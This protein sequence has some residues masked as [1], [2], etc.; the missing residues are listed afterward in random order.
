MVKTNEITAPAVLITD[1]AETHEKFIYPVTRVLAPTS[2]G[3][4]G[5]SGVVVYSQDKETYVLTNNHVIAGLIDIEEKWNSVAQRPLK[6]E[7]RS[8]AIVE[9]FSYE[10]MSR[11]TDAVSKKAD[12]VAWDEQKDLAL[13][14]LK[15]TVDVEYIA[16]IMHPREEVEKLFIS[17]PIRT[18]GCGLGVP[19]LMTVGTIGGFDFPIENYPYMLCTAPSIFGN[20]GGPVYSAESGEVIGLTA[21]ISVVMMGLGGSAITHMGW[22]IPTKTIHAFLEEQ[23]YDFIIDPEVDREESHKKREG[24]RKRAHEAQLLGKPTEEE[25]AGSLNDFVIGG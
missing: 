12:V 1:V 18:V 14:K 24:L 16:P 4:A 20:S 3:I 11:I 8:D 6:V 23:F 17:T 9:F 22:A 10:D 2:K 19:P 13:L 25:Q 7:T 21:R 5:G 15:S